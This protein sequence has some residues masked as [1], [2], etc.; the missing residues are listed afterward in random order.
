M[1]LLSHPTDVLCTA[2]SKF[3]KAQT[4]GCKYR[5]KHIVEAPSARA[6]SSLTLC[7]ITH[8]FIMMM[9]IWISRCFQKL[10]KR[11]WALAADW[12]LVL[13]RET[14]GGS[15]DKPHYPAKEHLCPKPGTKGW[16]GSPA[17]PA[18]ESIQHHLCREWVAQRGTRALWPEQMGLNTQP[19]S[20][21]LDSQL[22]CWN[23]AGTQV[24]L[25]TT[26]RTS[27]PKSDGP[28]CDTHGIWTLSVPWTYGYLGGH[29]FTTGPLQHLCAQMVLTWSGSW[30]PH[31]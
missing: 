12:E 31:G 30:V 25:H 23:G 20:C 24:S 21:L 13:I 3:E 6:N 2:K 11:I 7:P 1:S 14:P 22:D 10:T 28:N 18:K 8:I 26:V 19:D 9:S 16:R 29:Q 17:S 27:W 4:L 15:W 5:Y